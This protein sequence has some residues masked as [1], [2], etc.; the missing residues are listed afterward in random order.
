MLAMT[1]T[2]IDSQHRQVQDELEATQQEIADLQRKQTKL[3]QRLSRLN[4]HQEL[5]ADRAV[6]EYASWLPFSNQK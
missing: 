1:R 5:V 6:P 3:K 2:D 4:L